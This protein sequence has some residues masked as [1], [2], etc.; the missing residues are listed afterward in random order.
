[1]SSTAG[2]QWNTEALRA[3][4]FF[5]GQWPADSRLG[6]ETLFGVEIEEETI[7]ASGKEKI[8][9]GSLGAGRIHLQLTSGRCDLNWSA[10]PSSPA[11]QPNLGEISEALSNFS[12]RVS[13][14]F[15][16]TEISFS[17]LALG[18]VLVV[19]FENKAELY[20]E[21]RRIFPSITGGGVEIDDFLFQ[22]NYPILIEGKNYCLNR[23]RKIAA[24]EAQVAGF[25]ITPA[26]IIALPA[27]PKHALVCEIDFNNKPDQSA[28]FAGNEVRSFFE[29]AKHEVLGFL[30][31]VSHV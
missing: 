3:T 17:R 10:L 29:T 20:E 25:Q 18:A 5:D 15:S 19:P 28:F 13:E 31:G 8:Q 1:M 4:V 11:D 23:L 21:V 12:E 30:A 7:R 27:P 6:L 24:R 14:T 2:N 22:I 16:L 26:G 9:V